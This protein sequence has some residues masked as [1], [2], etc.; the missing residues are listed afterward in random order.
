ME[1]R[2]EQSDHEIL[3]ELLKEKKKTGR[4]LKWILGCVAAMAL[5]AVI[6]AVVIVPRAAD[7]LV[8]ARTAV[9][10]M[11]ALI[12]SLEPAANGISEIDYNSLNRSISSLEESTKGLEKLLGVFNH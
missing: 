12:D 6:A 8:D 10:S 11:D 1:E 7:L 3:E 9:N 2:Q 4:L 5:A